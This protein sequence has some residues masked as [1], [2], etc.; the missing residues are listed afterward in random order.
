MLF[1]LLKPGHAA[2]V[3][4]LDSDVLDFGYPQDLADVS[5]QEREVTEAQD[6]KAR[7]KGPGNACPG[8]SSL[9]QALKILQDNVQCDVIKIGGIIRNKARLLMRGIH[10]LSSRQFQKA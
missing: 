8:T 2:S 9:V 3:H 4:C 6:C 5:Q 10:I 1:S 7:I